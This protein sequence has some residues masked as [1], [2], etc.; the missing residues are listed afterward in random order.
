MLSKMKVN[1]STPTTWT[2]AW[3]WGSSETDAGLTKST[4]APTMGLEESLSGW[5]LEKTGLPMTLLSTAC[6]IMRTKYVM[7]SSRG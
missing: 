7:D 4:Q 2:T 3:S 5:P 1:T 6:G